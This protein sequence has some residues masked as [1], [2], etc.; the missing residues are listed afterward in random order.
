MDYTI[1]SI[2]TFLLTTIL[3]YVFVKPSFTIVHLENA[4]SLGDVL[5][6]QKYISGVFFLVVVAI[7]FIVNISAMA[8]HCGNGTA[9]NLGAAALYTFVPWI[10]MFG[11]MMI[12]LMVFPGLKSGFSNVVGYYA[13]AFSANNLLTELLLDPEIDAKIQSENATPEDRS[14]MQSAADAIL[15][16]LGNASILINQVV[17]G[18]FSQYWTTLVPLMKGKYKNNLDSIET[19]EKKQAFLNL[20]IMR[21]NIGEAC[22]YIYTGIFLITIVQYNIMTHKCDVDPEVANEKYKEY[23]KKEKEENEK[24]EKQNTVEYKMS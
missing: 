18:N 9:K 8:D 5:R 3:Y 14:A 17:P 13:V 19:R 11:V 16:L 2:F 23:N 4:K 12:V 24:K 7:Q 1:L 15:K 20:A 6:N 21:D 22:W 10:F